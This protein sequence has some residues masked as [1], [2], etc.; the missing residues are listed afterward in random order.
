MIKAKKEK[1][2]TSE[3]DG[4]ETMHFPCNVLIKECDGDNTDARVADK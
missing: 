3:D 4:K 1:R 2:K